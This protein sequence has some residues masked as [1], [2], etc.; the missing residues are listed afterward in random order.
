MGSSR[1]EAGGPDQ[2]IFFYVHR[3]NNGHDCQ[4]LS[5]LK[6]D[7][8]NCFFFY[9]GEDK[10]EGGP[11]SLSAQYSADSGESAHCKGN[12]V[13]PAHAQCELFCSDSLRL[14]ASLDT[15]CG[16]PPKGFL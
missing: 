8:L 13:P 2:P 6:V 5:D 4:S 3:I 15:G 7:K 12:A 9:K 16:A 11:Q 14:M 10:L 1:D